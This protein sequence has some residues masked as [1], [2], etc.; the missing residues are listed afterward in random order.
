MALEYKPRILNQWSPSA[1]TSSN[2]LT[3]NPNFPKTHQADLWTKIAFPKAF[4]TLSFHFP[5]RASPASPHRARECGAKAL[6]HD[7]KPSPG[8]NVGKP[9][10]SFEDLI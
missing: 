8:T 1:T 5:C 2:L 10:D 3:V 7:A 9:P 4:P 6:E